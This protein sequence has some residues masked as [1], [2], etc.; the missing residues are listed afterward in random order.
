MT[1]TDAD[2]QPLER[3]FNF[4]R[5]REKAA[6]ALRG[7]LQGVVADK[8]LG[9][10]ELLFLDAWLRSQQRLDSGDVVD[11]LD[12]ISDI[13]ADGVVTADELDELQELINDIIKY[14]EASSIEVEA[15]INELLGLLSGI[16]ADGE[17]TKSELH[18][19]KDWL[20]KNDQI[21]DHW[22]ANEI[23]NRIR[24][25]LA[26]GII[27]PDELEDLRDTLKH[28][29]GHEFDE[30]GSADGGVA[31]VFS[32]DPADF[33]HD[34]QTMCFTGKFVCGTR[35]AVENVAKER[36]ANIV[37]NVTKKTNVLVIGTIAS[38]DWRFTSHGRKIE[39]AL[40]LQRDEVPIVILSERQWRI[41]CS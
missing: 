17:V 8:K 12:L 21:A 13:L 24:Q 10:Q 20:E 31:E 30:S 7:L 35:S 22:P 16:V 32:D 39:K 18:S 14:G 6:F 19:L 34:G 28:I 23:T 40:S 2:G 38:R 15:S 11:L 29:C 37:K 4:R 41:L 9:S 36:G 1:K 25:V 5:N 33:D 27:T 26:D 3:R